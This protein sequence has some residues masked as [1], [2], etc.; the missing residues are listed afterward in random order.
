MTAAALYFTHYGATQ[1]AIPRLVE[2]E[3]GGGELQ[4]G[5]TLVAFSVA[6]IA[7]RLVMS[8]FAAADRLRGLMTAG[9]MLAAVS[10]LVLLIEDRLVAVLFVRAVHGVS[11]ALFFVAAATLVADLAPESRRAES[12][13][14]FSVA[15]FGGLGTGPFLAERVIGDDSFD[16]GFVLV[17]VFSAAATVI[18]LLL[19]KRLGEQASGSPAA[20]PTYVMRTAVWPGVVLAF[21]MIGVAT[22]VAFLPAQARDVGLADA[23]LVFVTYSGVCL[24]VRLAAARLPERFGLERAASVSLI[25]SALAFLLLAAVQKPIGLFGGA[26]LVA[27]GVSFLYPSLMAITINRVHPDKRL[28]AVSTLTLFFDVGSAVGGLTLGAVAQSTSKAAGFGV[29]SLCSVAGLAL[30]WLRVAERQSTTAPDDSRPQL[31][32]DQLADIKI[33]PTKGIKP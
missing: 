4:I 8:R 5:Y 22:F 24:F 9:A 29:A 6:A 11:L 13:S 16:A 12:A 33:N 19:P 26:A 1:A 15:I 28:A 31:A 10:T 32:G 3:L 25:G 20:A 7:T 30:L 17:A 27:I 18:C 2:E 21:G 23:G 14:Y